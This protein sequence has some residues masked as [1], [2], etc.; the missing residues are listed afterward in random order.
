MPANNARQALIL[1]GAD[2]L[3][4]KHGSAPG[5]SEVANV[6]TVGTIVFPGSQ[7]AP[8]KEDMKEIPGLWPKFVAR[9]DEIAHD[10][11]LAVNGYPAAAGQR[12]HVDAVAST[13]ERQ[14]D[15]V[16]AQAL[17]REAPAD[18]NLAHEVHRAL[19][20][21]AGTHA[22][23]DV[24]LAAILEDDR[25][26]AAQMQQLPEHQ[27]GGSGADNADLGAREHDRDV[28]LCAVRFGGPGRATPS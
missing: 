3:D 12:R 28:R 19:L 5:L 9:L 21:H 13:V 14:V 1:T 15:A 25:I 20:E 22:L 27:A 23:D 24:L 18:A 8:T 4:N 16:V 7:L 26:D 2:V 6:K 11:V 17:A 10:F